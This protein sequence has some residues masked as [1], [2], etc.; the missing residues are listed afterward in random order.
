MTNPKIS[1]LLPVYKSEDLL[2]K[3]FIPSLQN[4]SVNCEIVFYDNGGNNLQKNGLNSYFSF[5]SKNKSEIDWVPIVG[6]ENKGLNVAF[7]ECV[8][9][10][11][12]DYF[13]LCH[14]DMFLLPGWDIALLNAAKN[15]APGSFLYCSRSVEPGFSHIKSQIRKDYGNEVENFNHEQLM[16]EY[17]NYIENG[18]V[19]N[20]RMPFFL[21][22]KLWQRIGGVD[23]KF[24]SFCSDDD[25]IQ[26]CYDVGVRK[27]YMIYESLVYHLSGKSNNQ[28][29]VDKDKNWP[30]EYFVEKWRPKYPDAHHP[31]QWHPKLIPF[32][33]RVK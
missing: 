2:K 26:Q 33:Q 18:I 29:T 21:H 5:L 15:Q 4:C 17:Q 19:F 31:G 20:A 16:K 3:V 7:N 12:G 8:K 32:E 10:A 23:E 6:K 30:Y 1:I 27:F 14:T 28:Q 24:F 11:K 9:I 22:R 25:I 13:Y